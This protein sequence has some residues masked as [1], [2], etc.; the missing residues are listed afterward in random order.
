MSDVVTP[1]HAHFMWQCIID[2]EKTKAFT[3]SCDDT[4]TSLDWNCTNCGNYIANRTI[5]VAL[6]MGGLCTH[7]FATIIN[8]NPTSKLD[9]PGFDP[10]LDHLVTSRHLSL[11]DTNDVEKKASILTTVGLKDKDI[12][13]RVCADGDSIRAYFAAEGAPPR[14]MIFYN[15]FCLDS[16]TFRIL[17]GPPKFW[18]G[19][20]RRHRLC[21]DGQLKSVQNRGT[22][23]IR[24]HR[25]PHPI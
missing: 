2:C 15:P 24:S 9:I 17:V 4:T 10:L 12:V 16:P 3:L 1:F 6:H 22:M 5:A 21:V 23:S 8:S 25:L 7:C 18:V 14:C 20:E 11:L 13:D 19:F